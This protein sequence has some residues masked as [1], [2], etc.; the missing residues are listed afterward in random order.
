G[1]ERNREGEIVASYGQF[2][3]TN[4]QVNF[5]SH[6]TRFAY[7][8]SFNGNRSDLG[9]G[10]PSPAVIHDRVNG[11]GGFGTLVFNSSPANQFRLVTAVRQDFYQV[12]NDEQAQA[13]GIRDAERETD[14]LTHFSWVHAEGQGVL[15]TIS[16]FYHFNRANFA[17]GPD[18]TPVIAVDNHA[19]NYGGAQ[20]TLSAVWKKHNARA[21]FYG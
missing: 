4:D 1:F 11:F 6:T 19:S 5:G 18:D 10:T 3:Q 2:R 8:G 14:A 9:L 15:L 17:G 7:Y 12:P 13:Q 21:G 20:V 16:P